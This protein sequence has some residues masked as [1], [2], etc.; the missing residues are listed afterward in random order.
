MNIAREQ[1]FPRGLPAV[2]LR[3]SSELTLQ[4]V[5]KGTPCSR[6]WKKEVANLHGGRQVEALQKFFP[7]SAIGSVK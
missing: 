5:P 1:I 3:R 6:S 4:F 2:A 7:H